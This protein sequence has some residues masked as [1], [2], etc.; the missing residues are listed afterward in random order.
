MIRLSKFLHSQQ[1][2]AT[3]SRRPSYKPNF[4]AMYRSGK[5][6]TSQVN[7]RAVGRK[8]LVCGQQDEFLDL[9]LRDQHPIERIAMAPRKQGDLAGLRGRQGQALEDTSL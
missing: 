8:C 5:L 3:Y 9:R 4:P 1:E 6:S 2:G 7:D